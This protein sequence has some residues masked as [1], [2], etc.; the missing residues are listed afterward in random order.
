MQGALMD[1]ARVDVLN[2]VWFAA[3]LVDLVDGQRIFAVLAAGTV[4]DIDH[5][6]VRMHVHRAH[7]LAR[8][9]HGSQRALPL[10]QVGREDYPSPDATR[11]SLS[12][13]AVRVTLGSVF[14][15]AAW[16]A[17]AAANRIL[18]PKVNPRRLVDKLS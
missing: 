17:L 6:T 16:A 15:W 9:R 18:L 8:N 7:R 11:R 4:G 3:R 13:R 5:A 14:T 12:I 2:Q 1:P 10:N